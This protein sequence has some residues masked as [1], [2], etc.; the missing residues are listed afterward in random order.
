MQRLDRLQSLCS[1]CIHSQRGRD[2]EASRTLNR[3]WP[4][5]KHLGNILLSKILNTHAKHTQHSNHLPNLSTQTLHALKVD[6]CPLASGY[7]ST[8]FASTAPSWCIAPNPSTSVLLYLTLKACRTAS[9]PRLDRSEGLQSVHVHTHT[10]HNYTASTMLVLD[11]QL[12][13]H[14]SEILYSWKFLNTHEVHKQHSNQL[15]SS[16]DTLSMLCKSIYIHWHQDIPIL[17]LPV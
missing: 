5:V 16:Q 4:L 9:I 8:L 7:S 2:Y 1:A 12:V 14:L 6:K 11:C 17:C 10:H 3:G 15:P 13:K